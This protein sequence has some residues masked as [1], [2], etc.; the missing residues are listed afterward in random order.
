MTNFT[1]GQ[2]NYKNL[3]IDRCVS[4]WKR[5]L[6][7]YDTDQYTEEEFIKLFHENE[8]NG[9]KPEPEYTSVSYEEIDFD[10]MMF[11]DF[12]KWIFVHNFCIVEYFAKKV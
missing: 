12:C 3:S 9:I 2:P 8:K 4:V 10:N 6:I 5:E 7:E 11:G 1:Q